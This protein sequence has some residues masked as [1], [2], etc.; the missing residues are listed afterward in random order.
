MFNFLFFE[1]LVRVKQARK[2]IPPEM[3]VKIYKIYALHVMI[4]F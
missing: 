2:P 3:M 1:S 4:A